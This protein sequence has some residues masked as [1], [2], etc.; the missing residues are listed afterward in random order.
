MTIH[1]IPLTSEAEIEQL[2]ER[3]DKIPCLIFKHSTRCNISSVA[4][5]RLESDWNFDTTQME[6]YFL[7]LLNYR[8][9]SGRIADVF[10]IYHESPQ[11]LLI[12]NGECIYD[13]SHLSISVDEL[14]EALDSVASK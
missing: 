10:Q 8:T 14:N 3:S 9:V 2:K 12:I 7:D 1:W 13:A 5:Y 11:V 4:R 6:A